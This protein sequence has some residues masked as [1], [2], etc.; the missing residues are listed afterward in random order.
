VLQSKGVRAGRVVAWLAGIGLVAGVAAA[1]VELQGSLGS[2][3]LKN[4]D[5]Q[6]GVCSQLRCA[7]T[8]PL[9]D[10]EP[11][12][13]ASD[14]EVDAAQSPESDG[15]AGPVPD[16]TRSTDASPGVDAPPPDAVAMPADAPAD[17]IDEGPTPDAPGDAPS[18][19]RLDAGETG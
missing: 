13:D 9:L 6:S 1:C 8:P 19:A 10:A 14:A 5:C 12:P 11:V 15:P 2:D 7:A 3:C 16:A 17:A 4:Q 18:D